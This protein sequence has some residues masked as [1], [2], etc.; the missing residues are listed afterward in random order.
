MNFV[1]E[2]V[3]AV[4]LVVGC[5]VRIASQ[6]QLRITVGSLDTTTSIRSANV[7]PRCSMGMRERSGTSQESIDPLLLSC[8]ETGSPQR[9][10]PAPG[11]EQ[12]FASLDAC[13]YQGGGVEMNFEMKET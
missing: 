3:I 2:D 5:T 1:L 11:R 12:R 8:A 7:D 13:G 9:G 6:L 10:S 4:R